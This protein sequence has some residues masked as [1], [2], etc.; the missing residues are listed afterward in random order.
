[1][2]CDKKKLEKTVFYFR[3]YL[4]GFL[5]D[6]LLKFKNKKSIKTKIIIVV[7][8]LVFVSCLSIGAVLGIRLIGTLNKQIESSIYEYAKNGA[9]ILQGEIQSNFRILDVAAGKNEIRDSSVPNSE[10]IKFLISDAEA[11]KTYGILRFGIAGPDG[12]SYMT[13]GN[14]S[15]VSSRDYFKASMNGE[16]FITSPTLAKSDNALVSMYS[17][18]LYDENNNISAVLFAVVDANFLCEVLKDFYKD[19]D[20]SVWAIDKDGNTVVDQDFANLES[21]ENMYERLKTDP[22]AKSIC[23]LYDKALMGKSSVENYVYL[24]G[25]EY[26]ISY[27]PIEGT[28]WIL[29]AET[30]EDIAFDPI[31]SAAFICAN[32]CVVILIIAAVFIGFYAE[33]FVAPIRK[34]SSF[35]GKI[36]DGDLTISQVEKKA[37]DN[38]SKSNTEIGDICKSVSLLREKLY[39][40]IE[41]VS[42]NANDLASKAEQISSASMELSSSSSVQAAAAENIANA[43]TDIAHAINET[44]Y[45]AEETGKLTHN[46]VLNTRTGGETI[47]NAVEAVKDIAKKV[48]VIEDIASNTNLLALNAAIEAARVGE[49]GKGFAVVAG[50]VR[51]LAENTTVSASDI[52]S[53]ST[54]TVSLADSAITV[55]DSIIK[56]VEK[57]ERLI[58]EI[59]V[60]N[61][62]QDEGTEKVKTT[63]NNLSNAVQQNASFSEELSAMAEDLTAQSQNLLDIMKYF[64]IS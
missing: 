22:M 45:N 49:A 3:I 11:N 62:N 56:E 15:D 6:V 53:I 1:M 57:T 35:I 64:N 61:R 58:D 44:R 7:S 18:P 25:V 27:A 28:N 12:K 43:V 19:V 9:R 10:K 31:R 37:L 47:S 42:F 39:D 21:Q 17:V 38:L 63:V 33:K 50:E 46:V 48:I 30:P 40:V 2:F 23:N 26:T 55:L 20:G 14:S 16:K 13:N 54:E 59:V 52:S 5:E 41:R 36:A 32:I 8:L 60:A 34:A 29:F 51:R 24:D 4:D